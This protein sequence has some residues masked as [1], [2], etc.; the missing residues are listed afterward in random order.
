METTKKFIAI[1]PKQE[2][3][4]ITRRVV[5]LR[6]EAK[7]NGWDKEWKNECDEHNSRPGDRDA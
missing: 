1:L 5:A 6:T 3:A 7:Y 2:K 4:K